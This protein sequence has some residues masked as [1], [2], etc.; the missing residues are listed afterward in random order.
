MI[1][2]NKYNFYSEMLPPGVVPGV[3][4]GAPALGAPPQQRKQQSVPKANFSGVMSW[5]SIII[6]L[7]IFGFLIFTIVILISIRK[8]VGRIYKREKYIP[9]HEQFKTP[10]NGE[11]EEEGYATE[12][13]DEDSPKT[14][15]KTRAPE[16]GYKADA[17]SDDEETTKTKKKTRAPE[18]GYK[19]DADS[20]DEETPKPKKKTLAPEDFIPIYKNNTIVSEGYYTSAGE[21]YIQQHPR[22]L[23][24]IFA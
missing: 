3:V 8:R 5:I 6:N 23:F 17:D 13:D 1:K 10:L 15:K 14:K 19:A 7:V 21:N 2:I 18:E 24:N 22:R 9:T 4:T 11:N 20:D 16:E 12:S